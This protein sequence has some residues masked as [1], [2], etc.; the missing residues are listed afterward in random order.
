MELIVGPNEERISLKRFL[1]L[2]LPGLSQMYLA[3]RVH[4]GECMVEGEVMSSWGRKMRAGERVE[5]NVDLDADTARKPENLPL[6]ILHEDERMLV[7]SKAPGMLVHPTK[8]VKSGT[9]ANAVAW[10]LKGG[11]FWF[12]HRLDRETS[13]VLIVAKTAEAMREISL[14][15]M[16]KAVQ[17]R[18]LA[19]VEGAVQTPELRIDAPIHR[20]GEQRPQWHVSPLGK[21]AVTLLK[22]E[23]RLSSHTLL[24]LQPV[25]GRTNQLRIHCAHIGHPIVGDTLYGSGPADRLWLHAEYA[26]LGGLQFLARPQWVLPGEESADRL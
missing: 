23:R 1:A 13:G 20:D 8:A 14:L 3:T 12:P 18:Y 19:L 16:Q 15:W 6:E 5:I 25:T 21:E 24:S 2:R 17:K 9:L 22:V 26:A 10:H 4:Q 7:L 11:R